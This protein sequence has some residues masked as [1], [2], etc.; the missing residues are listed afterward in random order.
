MDKAKES[1]HR[2]CP[3][4]LGYFLASPLR[5]L[6]Y[7]PRT[8]LA[9]Y[10]KEGMTV[11]D[12]GSAMGFFSIPLAQMVGPAGKV[13]CV[14]MQEKMLARLKKPAQKAGVSA[15]IETRL[16]TQD[17]PGLEPLAGTIDFAL[18]FAVV[19]EVPARAALFAGVA[20]ALK[21]QAKLLLAEPKGHVSAEDFARTL[22]IAKE[23]G[24]VEVAKPQIF[25]SYA[26]LL[27][28]PP[29]N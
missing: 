21:P 19:H 1:A 4:W 17:A 6:E 9:P 12:F 13:I 25:R 20:A 11:L 8:I 7:N 16:C 18:L 22:S 23:Q 28:R 2:V 29:A 10:V 24:F 15:Q 5:K 14:D 26:V 27:Q 3:W